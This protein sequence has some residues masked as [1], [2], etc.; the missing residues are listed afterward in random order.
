MKNN[1]DEQCT[2]DITG[3]CD[4]WNKIDTLR[5]LL[6][7]PEGLRIGQHIVNQTDDAYY[8]SDVEFINLVK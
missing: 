7:V 8:V 1:H 2:K 3:L 4:C 6:N 5:K